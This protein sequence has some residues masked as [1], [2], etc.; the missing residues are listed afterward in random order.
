MAAYSDLVSV[1]EAWAYNGTLW[2]WTGVPQSRNAIAHAEENSWSPQETVMRLVWRRWEP[3]PLLCNV[4][5]FDRA[6]RHLATPDL[7]DPE[8]GV[9]GEYDGEQ[10]LLGSQRARDVRRESAIR[11]AGLEYVTMLAA[12]HVDHYASFLMRLESTYARS[13][14]DA[15]SDRAWTITP[16]PWWV[17]T[18]TV[19]ARRGLDP[20]LR[21]RLLKHRHVA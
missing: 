14:F 19:A 11:A 21:S 18:T 16:P 1:V 8:G 10:H 20:L 2:T 6:G 7:L 4:P 9:M 15:E 17:D 13:R 5:V 12:D 3:R